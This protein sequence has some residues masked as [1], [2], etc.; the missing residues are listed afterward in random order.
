VSAALVPEVAEARDHVRS[1]AIASGATGTPTIFVDGLRYLGSYERAQ[2]GRALST[3][4][5]EAE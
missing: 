2:L 1:S 4:G 5:E 3:D